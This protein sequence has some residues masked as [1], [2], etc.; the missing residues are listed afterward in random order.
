MEKAGPLF[1]KIKNAAD[2]ATD[3]VTAAVEDIRSSKEGPKGKLASA[4][5][6]AS[7]VAEQARLALQ[8]YKEMALRWIEAQTWDELR[9]GTLVVPYEDLEKGI[10]EAMK[11]SE[12][13]FGGC[14]YAKDG[15]LELVVE[16]GKYGTITIDAGIEAFALT[17]SASYGRF[18]I[19]DFAVSENKIGELVVKASWLAPHHES[20][21][22]GLQYEDHQQG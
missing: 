16:H 17:S 12:F 2:T 22:C 15:L 4:M 1:D 14:H 21:Q 13:R 9:S 18:R 3:K 6:A 20:C 5:D 8:P 7:D 11:D 19:H 10:R